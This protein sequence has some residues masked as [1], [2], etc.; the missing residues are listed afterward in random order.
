[1]LNNG[2]FRISRIFFRNLF[3]PFKNA[4]V[5]TPFLSNFNQ[6]NKIIINTFLYLIEHD[7]VSGTLIPIPLMNL[8]EEN[9]TFKLLQVE[10]KNHDWGSRDCQWDQS[11]DH[12]GW[13]IVWAASC[14]HVF[15]FSYLI[16]RYYSLFRK[17]WMILLASLVLSKSLENGSSTTSSLNISS[18]LKDLKRIITN[19]LK[20]WL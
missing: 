14:H 9:S 6:V 5:P 20:N 10:S 15:Q 11:S 7:W 4:S 8:T 1:M 3:N 13:K 19:G 12:V 18:M 17:I 2:Y 16:E